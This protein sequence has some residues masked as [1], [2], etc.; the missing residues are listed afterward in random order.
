MH[1]LQP[2]EAQFLVEYRAIKEFRWSHEEYV[3]TPSYVTQ[4]LLGIAGIEHAIEKE[5]HDQA[6]QEAK[7]RR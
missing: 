1:L 3:R 2:V 5:K 7:A 4:W 6:M